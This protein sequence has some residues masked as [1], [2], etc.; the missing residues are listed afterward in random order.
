M[1]C[2]RAFL[3]H[4]PVLQENFFLDDGAYGA[5]KI[6]IEAVRR[7]LDGAG[8]ISELVAALR[9]P[10]EAME[11]RVK[12]TADDVAAEGARV[13]AAFHEWMGSGAGGAAHWRLEDEN[14]EGWRVRVAEGGEKEGWVLVR[15]SLHDPGKQSRG[16]RVWRLF[17]LVLV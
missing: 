13:T 3:P 16:E 6:V 1:H 12:I 11:I 17:S 9:E 2:Q 15:P 10:V 8:D 4:F 14:Y 5:L 7:R